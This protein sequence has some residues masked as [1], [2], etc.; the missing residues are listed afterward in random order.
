MERPARVASPHRGLRVA[1]VLIRLLLVGA[2]VVLLALIAMR[3][4][5]GFTAATVH[6]RAATSTS[7]AAQL[8]GMPAPLPATPVATALTAAGGGGA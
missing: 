4:V 3:E 2:L 5:A 1:H 7:G 8:A 6:G